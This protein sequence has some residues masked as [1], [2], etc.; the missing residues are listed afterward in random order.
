MAANI[1]YNGKH[2]LAVGRG[3]TK[4]AGFL[5]RAAASN[6]ATNAAGIGIRLKK[7][8]AGRYKMGLQHAFGYEMQAHGGE[9]KAQGNEMKELGSEMNALW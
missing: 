9:M 4:K 6:I 7:R 2:G 3:A 8:Q 1:F 5:P